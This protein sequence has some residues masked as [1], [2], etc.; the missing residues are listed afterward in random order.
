MKKTA[1]RLVV[2]NWKMNPQGISM[3]RRLVTEIKGGMKRAG[4][5]EVVLAPPFVYL[6]EAKA[7]QS[8][9][10]L[11]SI[12]AQDVHWEKLGAKTGEI[13]IPMLKNF[14]VTHVILGHSERRALGENDED[15]NRKALATIKAGLTAVVCVGE[16][17]RDSGAEYFSFVE[18]QVRKACAGISK[19]KL[20]G[21]VV[22]YEPI[23]AIGTGNN[24]TPEDAHEMKLF[25]QKILAD[26]HGR[27][28]GS[29]VRILYGGS[30]NARNAK[31]L[32]ENGTI[33]GFLVGGA[34]LKADEFLAII[35][36]A[37]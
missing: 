32:V 2:G 20:E 31:E 24:A 28:F 25:I 14:G 12:G 1:R 17:K 34:S 9:S 35:K 36:A 13:S 10:K 19:A 8:G 27:N 7:V 3:A 4:N 22:A 23:W 30:V 26:L 15:V 37:A 6:G 33:D 21:L 16:Q 5:V 11:F 18:N 29:K